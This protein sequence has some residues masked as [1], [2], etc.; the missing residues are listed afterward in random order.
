MKKFIAMLMSLAMLLSLA[1]CSSGGGSTTESGSGNSAP[2]TGATESAPAES[3]AAQEN[4]V[5]NSGQTY[6]LRMSCE[7]SEGQWLADMLQEYADAVNEATDGQVEIE[8]YLGNSLGS[9]DDIWSMFSAGTIDMIHA[10]VAHAGNFPV[11]DIVQTPFVVDSPEMALAVMEGL[12]EEGYLTE[13]TDNMHVVAYMPTLMQEFMFVDKEVTTV[14]DLSGM[15]I[16]ASSTP[17]VTCVESLGSTATS[18]AITDLYMSLSQ[19]VADGTITSVDA[20]EVFALY[21]VCDYL[22]D[23]PI[24]TG[25]NF[26][27]INLD[28]WNSLPA[29]IQEAMDQVGAEY[30]QKYIELNT[31]AGEDCT[32]TMV[33]GGTTILEPSD[34][35]TQACKD[36]T[37]G[38]VDALIA[39]LNE[40]GY[41]GDAI[42]AAAQEI[43]SQYNG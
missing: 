9:A 23:M 40:Q 36:A 30:Q 38:M 21:D 16:R 22:L 2:E 15:V 26:V 11:T 10:G 39:S 8:L 34:E 28:V 33:N 18:I 7:A 31:Q 13:F 3:G 42:V 17:L 37:S 25:M 32:E 29:D 12:A 4:K 35:L 41:D 27:G 43:V 19:G 5:E 14:D 6:S 24:C 20:A 1:A